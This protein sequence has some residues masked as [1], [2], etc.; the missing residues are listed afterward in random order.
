MKWSKATDIS[1]LFAILAFNYAFPEEGSDLCMNFLCL[2]SRS[3][4]IFTP[5]FFVRPQSRSERGL[6]IASPGFVVLHEKG[7]KISFR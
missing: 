4:K 2:I 7:K 1:I 5:S 6:F 3:K